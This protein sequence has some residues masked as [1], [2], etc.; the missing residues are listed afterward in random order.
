MT[1]SSGSATGASPPPIPSRPCASSI[2][3]ISVTECRRPEDDA[4]EELRLQ[5]PTTISGA[6]EAWFA[7]FYAPG[8]QRERDRK[9]FSRP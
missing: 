5:K 3:S 9:T 8:S 6:A 2:T 1:T 4:P 7:R